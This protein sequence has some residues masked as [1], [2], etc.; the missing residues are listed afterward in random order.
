M[1]VKLIDLG[2]LR[3]AWILRSFR[4]KGSSASDTACPTPD[5]TGMN[6]L[7]WNFW[8]AINPTFCNVVSDMIRR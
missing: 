7:I 2:F 4:A 1:K 6:M 3:W 5:W 8:G